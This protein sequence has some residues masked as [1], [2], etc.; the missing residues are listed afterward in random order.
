MGVWMQ[1]T[2]PWYPDP[3]AAGLQ[4]TVGVAAPVQC[5]KDVP[6]WLAVSFPTHLLHRC[7]SVQVGKLTH[8]PHLTLG[9]G[10]LFLPQGLEINLTV[11]FQK[12]LSQ[13]QKMRPGL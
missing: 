4:G 5:S 3:P 8:L 6:V 10:L 2:P 7:E 9:K 12:R 11:Y 13:L 1:N